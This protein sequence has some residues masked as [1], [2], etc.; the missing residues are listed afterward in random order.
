MEKSY[1]VTAVTRKLFKVRLISSLHLSRSIIIQ[2][3]S[4]IVCTAEESGGMGPGTLG[5]PRLHCIEQPSSA[6]PCSEIVCVTEDGRV[7][8]RGCGAGLPA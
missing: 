4:V 5:S 6:Q 8:G 1:L 2:Q 7:G 3:D